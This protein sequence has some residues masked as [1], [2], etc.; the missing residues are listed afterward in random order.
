MFVSDKGESIV[1]L[2]A[3][4]AS[5]PTLWPRWRAFADA[6]LAEKG[7]VVRRGIDRELRAAT[8][9]GVLL[10]MVFGG[11]LLHYLAS[12]DRRAPAVHSDEDYPQMRVAAA[13]RTAATDLT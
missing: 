1:R 7:P 8:D 3:E 5:I 11:L 13:I 4:V 2:S 10:D 6:L 12:A 9:V